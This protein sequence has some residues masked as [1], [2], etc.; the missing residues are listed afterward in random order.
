M[1]LEKFDLIKMS[2]RSFVPQVPQSREFLHPVFLPPRTTKTFQVPV[3]QAAPVILTPTTNPTQTMPQSVQSSSV[4]PATLPVKNDNTD[5]VISSSVRKCVVCQKPVKGHR[6]PCGRNKCKNGQ[7]NPD[8]LESNN[9]PVTMEPYVSPPG[10]PDQSSE[11][12]YQTPPQPYSP[13]EVCLTPPPNY[14]DTIDFDLP[15][16]DWME[17]LPPQSTIYI[18]LNNIE[19]GQTVANVTH[20]ASLSS[21]ETNKKKKADDEDTT[22]VKKKKGSIYFGALVKNIFS[23]SGLLEP[24][25]VRNR[26]QSKTDAKRRAEPVENQYSEREAPIPVSTTSNVTSDQSVDITE[27]LDESSTD[28]N[29]AAEASKHKK[30]IK[31]CN[32]KS[33]EFCNV[34]ENCRA[35]DS[36][37]NPKLKQK[38]FLR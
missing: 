29:P 30:Q 35:C 12:E 10:S 1:I 20:D 24:M 27:D 11:D 19:L 2:L 8:F 31:T 33:C 32:E 3:K 6:G 17:I 18:D 5:N 13:K 26:K 37:V 4:Q 22:R 36:C 28:N 25:T 7:I 21:V 16:E 38:C 23:S 34:S 14:D 9:T 15:N